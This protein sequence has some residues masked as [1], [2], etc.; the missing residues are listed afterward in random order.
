MHTLK[1]NGQAQAFPDGL[2]KTL[3]ELLTVLN[4][5]E[6]TVVAKVDEQIVRRTDFASTPLQSGQSCRFM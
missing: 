1:I 4:I 6:A 3:Q 5:S 2:P